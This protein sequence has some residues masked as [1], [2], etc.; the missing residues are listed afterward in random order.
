MDM[1]ALVKKVKQRPDFGRAGMVLCHNGVVRGTTADGKQKVTA[2]TVQVDHDQ[3]AQVIAEHKEMPGIIDIQA[4]IAEDRQLNVGDD[5]MLV[6]VAGDVR[7]NVI[8]AMAS[9]IDAIKSRVTSKTQAYE[10]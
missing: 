9:L 3:L 6:V 2:L 5:I 4:E 7:T 10:E 1:A 8:P